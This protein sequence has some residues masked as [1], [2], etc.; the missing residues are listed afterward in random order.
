MRA[1]LAVVVLLVAASS[2]HAAVTNVPQPTPPWV[3][4]SLATPRPPADPDDW[5]VLSKTN[6]IWDFSTQL[7]TLPEDT[8]DGTV[9]KV[10][11]TD[12]PVFAAYRNSRWYVHDLTPEFDLGLTAVLIAEGGQIGDGRG[13]SREVTYSGAGGHSRT[14]VHPGFTIPE[15][16]GFALA[17]GAAVAVLRRRR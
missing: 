13:A 15:P 11:W 1:A 14:V 3:Q 7:N 10:F 16:S 5:R 17:A 9:K 12:A 8:S 6:G 4:V 2:A